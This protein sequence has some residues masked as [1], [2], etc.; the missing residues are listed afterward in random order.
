[1]AANKK[2]ILRAGA[3]LILLGFVLPSMTVSCSALPSV[4]KS[5]SLYDL[6]NMANQTVLYLVPLAI[7]MVI[8]FSFLPAQ[9]AR[10]TTQYYWGQVIGIALSGLAIFIS[11]F[12]VYNQ[13][14]QA[15]SELFTVTPEVGLF[16]LSLGYILAVIGL[17]II[18]RE[19]NSSPQIYR[20]DSGSNM[21][22]SGYVSRGDPP[23]VNAYLPFCRLEL[24]RGDSPERMVLIRADNYSIGRGSGN[25]LQLFDPQVSRSH[26]RLRFVQGVWY[27][28]DQ[29]SALGTKVNNVTTAATRLNS[30]DEIT[31][32]NTTFR[33]IQ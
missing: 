31:L 33:F 6:A 32:G 29:Q 11:V 26:V 9:D 30:G 24:L 27:I 10:Q 22:Q 21:V 13:I 20:I 14:N 18:G 28:Q 8:I 3:L 4:G 2:W 23:P 7:V 16:I 19:L 5:L 25:D 15:G 12:S 1:M 17:I